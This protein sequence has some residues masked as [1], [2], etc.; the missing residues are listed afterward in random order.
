M[1]QIQNQLKKK[2]S[3]QKYFQIPNHHHN[4]R[5]KNQK[6]DDCKNK[7]T[8][9]QNII[10]SIPKTDSN[11]TSTLIGKFPGH[12]PDRFMENSSIKILWLLKS[13]RLLRVN[14]MTHCFFVKWYFAL[15]SSPLEQK[16]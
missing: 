6:Y 5:H 2:K 11:L 10:V 1:C 4:H 7:I 3:K 12:D 16:L 8:P 13:W 14:A 9:N 15:G